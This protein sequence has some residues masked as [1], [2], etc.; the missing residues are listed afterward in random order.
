[1]C[2]RASIVYSIGHGMCVWLNRLDNPARTSSLRLPVVWLYGRWH[3]TTKTLASPQKVVLRYAVLEEGS[4]PSL[5]STAQRIE[6][7]GQVPVLA[8]HV[9]F[10]CGNLNQLPVQRFS[11]TSTTENIKGHLRPRLRTDSPTSH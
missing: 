4:N 10:R 3:K 11:S 7:G 8:E 1:M 9:L 5:S 6:Y 2:V